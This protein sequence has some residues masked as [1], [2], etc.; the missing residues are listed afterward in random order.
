MLILDS[1]FLHCAN[2]LCL[3]YNVNEREDLFDSSS[4]RLLKTTKHLAELKACVT[5]QRMCKLWQMLIIFKPIAS[6]LD[7]TQRNLH[8]SSLLFATRFKPAGGIVLFYMYIS[9]YF[10]AGLPHARK[11]AWDRAPYS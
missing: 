5:V 1:S 4:V 3:G 9:P 8:I 6:K 2:Q 10:I 11:R 7:C